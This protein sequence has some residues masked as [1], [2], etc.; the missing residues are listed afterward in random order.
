[1]DILDSAYLDAARHSVLTP[2][3]LSLSYRDKDSGRIFYR[4]TE[5]S[6]TEDI[7]ESGGEDETILQK[8]YSHSEKIG[9]VVLM[10]EGFAFSFAERCETLPIFDKDTSLLLGSNIFCTSPDKITDTM[11]ETDAK[12]LLLRGRFAVVISYGLHNAIRLTYALEMAA[13]AER[14]KRFLYG[15]E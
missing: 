1:M 11:R 6:P 12:A 9:A 13:K 8:I 7:T 14:V 10:R 4:R 5:S 2:Y 3:G 15:L